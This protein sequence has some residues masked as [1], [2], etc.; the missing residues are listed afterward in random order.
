M[1]LAKANESKNTCTI[2]IPIPL[3]FSG[4][5][6]VE[7]TGNTLT[8]PGDSGD[9]KVLVKRKDNLTT[10][11]LPT[12]AAEQL[13]I[14]EG[15]LVKV[16]VEGGKV[17]IERPDRIPLEEYLYLMAL[18]YHASLVN[19]MKKDLKVKL[20]EIQVL[21]WPDVLLSGKKIHNDIYADPSGNIAFKENP[22]LPTTFLTALYIVKGFD[23]EDARALARITHIAHREG[24]VRGSIEKLPEIKEEDLENALAEVGSND[25]SDLLVDIGLVNRPWELVKSLV[26]EYPSTEV[27]KL[28]LTLLKLLD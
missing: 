9:V 14:Y 20:P 24:V 3:P 13:R 5:V 8:M 15:T 6:G 7:I 21:Q 23:Y 12:L 16:T 28:V 25:I 17:I 11:I 2:T 1:L 27:A 18:P 22:P 10:I 26:M 4:E 19:Y